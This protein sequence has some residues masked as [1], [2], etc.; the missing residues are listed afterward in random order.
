MKVLVLNYEYPPLGGGAA[1]AT[2]YIL[3]EFSSFKNLEIDLITSGIGKFRVDEI[4]DNVRIH[5]LDIG[6][7]EK[8]LH[9]QSNKDLLVYSKKAYFYSK[10]LM[11]KEKFDLIHAFFGIPCG[12]IAQKLKL[13]YIVSLRGSDVPFYSKK[14]YWFDKFF[15]KRLSKRIWKKSDAVIANSNGL[16]ELA[17]SCV[18]GQKIGVIYN[19]IDVDEFVAKKS[20]SRTGKLKALCV[21]RLIERKGFGFVVEATRKLKGKVSVD[22]AGD[23][24]KL[25]SLKKMSRGL[26]VNFLGLVSHDKLGKIYRNYDVF[27]LPSF[28]EGMSNTVLEAMAAGLGIIVTDTGGTR[29]LLNGNGFMVKSGSSDDIADK[30][31]LYLEDRRLVEKHGKKSRKLAENMSWE[32]VAK[33]YFK[34]YEKVV[35]K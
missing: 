21:G 20:Y 30:L 3:Q 32:K 1:N 12:F 13:P 6:K 33:D 31:R 10:R 35:K 15:F 14:Y 8:E 19:G 17:L 16:R 5:Y 18:P 25:D 11:K 9:N 24:P 26:D 34:L 27:V 4:Y 7:N 22:F 29:E 28:N 23:G 2:K